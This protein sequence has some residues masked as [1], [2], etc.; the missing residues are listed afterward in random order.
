MPR[1][2]HLLYV[3]EHGPTPPIAAELTRGGFD[4]SFTCAR[5]PEDLAQQ[6]AGK[7]DLAIGLFE[8]GAF[9]AFDILRAVGE[10]N[11]DLPVIVVSRRVKDGYVT[12]LLKQGAADHIVLSNLMR[13][14]AAV[15]RELRAVALRRDRG[16]LEE[17]FRQAQK[18]EA[19]GRLAGGVAHDFNNLL[20]VITGYSDL[21]LNRGGLKD[22]Q[23]TALEE[24]RRAAERGGAL[25]HQLLAFSRRQPLQLRSVQVNELVMH[26]QKLLRRLIGEDVSLVILPGAAHDIVEADPGRI[27]QVIMNMAVNARDA[28]PGGGSLTIETSNIEVSPQYLAQHLGVAAGRYL[29]LTIA[30]TGHGMDNETL[31]HL[32]EPFFT[33]KTPGRGTGLGLATA[34]GIIRQSGGA[35]QFSSQPGQGTTAFLY[36]PLSAKAEPEL[37]AEKEHLDQEGVETILVVED[38][39]R[40]RKL[41]CSVLGN[42]GYSIVEA[43][44]GEEAIR[45]AAAHDGPIHLILVDVIMPGMSGPEVARQIQSS[46]PSTRVLYIS[47][48]TDEAMVHHRIH[49]SGA[50]FLPK[51]FLP[52]VLTRKVR[53]VLDSRQGTSPAV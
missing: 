42:R 37:A 16:Q 10:R 48:Y 35:I 38:D 18:M 11:L 7:W 8:P 21:L 49:D 31:S 13:L 45:A 12:A 51:P 43:A 15:E 6:L 17:Q 47:G 53:D 24:I 39:A 9:G 26:L 44:R 46:R 25:T 28:M 50:A 1:L 29:M 2:L 3:G 22:A 23:K 4:P 14:N 20:T 33:T 27:E 19:V 41:I 34:Y 40:V 5:T 32:F 36:L 52:R 30:D